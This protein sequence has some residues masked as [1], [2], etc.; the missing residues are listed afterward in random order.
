[1]D[2]FYSYF[3]T[4]G[5]GA[6]R[7]NGLIFNVDPQYPR[8][9]SYDCTINPKLEIYNYLGESMEI[10]DCVTILNCCHSSYATRE[11]NVQ[12]RSAE[13]LSAVRED[14]SAFPKAIDSAGKV[15][16]R[17]FRSKLSAQVSHRRGKGHESISFLAAVEELK[18]HS[19]RNRMPQFKILFG[20]TSAVRVPLLSP[21]STLVERPVRQS[22][23]R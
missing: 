18:T 13:V 2:G 8:T 10:F 11:S 21:S 15:T 1:M 3:T 4:Q 20:S 6:V 7:G 9:F 19:N 14:Q 5:M 17:N 23:F 22:F 16:A 12:T